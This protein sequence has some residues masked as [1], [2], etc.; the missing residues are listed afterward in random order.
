MKLFLLPF[1]LACCVCHAQLIFTVSNGPRS[2]LFQ[3]T[4]GAVTGINTG[5]SDHRAMSLSR[6]G[7][8]VIFGA[9]VDGN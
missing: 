3:Q 9:V 2:G 8:F 4:G 6:D 7:R 1:L 5:F